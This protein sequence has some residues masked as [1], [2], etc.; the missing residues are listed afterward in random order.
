VTSVHE[1]DEDDAV[2]ALMGLTSQGERSIERFIS[3]AADRNEEIREAGE[4]SLSKKPFH[5]SKR[6]SKK[7]GKANAFTFPVQPRVVQVIKMPKTYVDHTYRDFS[8]VPP[9]P[10]YREPPEISQMTFAQKLH[11]MLSQ[12]EYSDCI[13]WLPHGRAFRIIS[14]KMMEQTRLL[15]TYYGHNRYSGFLMELKKYGLKLMTGGRDSNCYYHE[16]SEEKPSLNVRCKNE[17]LLS[18]IIANPLHSPLI[19]L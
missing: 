3:E 17:S 18:V 19:R 6:S 15:Q 5:D 7:K 12:S 4:I 14:P 10:G 9:E 2:A 11:H 8:S 13:N 1:M 16:V